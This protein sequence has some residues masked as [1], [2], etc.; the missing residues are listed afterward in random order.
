MWARKL[1][2]GH[3]L[4]ADG[5]A[6]DDAA[7]LPLSLAESFAVCFEV[8]FDDS[9]AESLAANLAASL[10]WLFAISLAVS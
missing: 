1:L 4:L 6:T 3:W 2:D 7:F 8:S 10:P 5:C 9:F